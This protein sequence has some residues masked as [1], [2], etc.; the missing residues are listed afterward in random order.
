M[1]ASS[2]RS[3][4]S[5]GHA[6]KVLV[7]ITSMPKRSCLGN[8]HPPRPCSTASCSTSTCFAVR[9]PDGASLPG[10]PRHVPAPQTSTKPR[11]AGATAS[12]TRFLSE[13][14]HSNLRETLNARSSASARIPAKTKGH[15]GPTTVHQITTKLHVDWLNINLAT[16]GSTVDVRA[17]QKPVLFLTWE[18]S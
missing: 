5:T 2:S 15:L 3:S 1:G 13:L 18:F 6:R 16:I 10:P 14:R 12:R 4:T 8:A 11:A 17:W 7:Y 9:G